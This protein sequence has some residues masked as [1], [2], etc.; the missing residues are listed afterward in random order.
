LLPEL[1]GV[2]SDWVGF[3][4]DAYK[5]V[6]V[7]YPLKDRVREKEILEKPI[8]LDFWTQHE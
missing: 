2:G 3:D 7:S 4:C 6:T 1:A 5:M 8:M